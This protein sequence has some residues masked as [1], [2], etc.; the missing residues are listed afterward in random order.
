MGCTTVTD[1]LHTG[2]VVSIRSPLT[3]T[4]TSCRH[5]S[6]TLTILL[7]AEGHCLEHFLHKQHPGWTV[8][9]Y[10]KHR[11]FSLTSIPVQSTEAGLYAKRHNYTVNLRNHFFTPLSTKINT[12]FITQQVSP[13]P[14][15]DS[16][17]RHA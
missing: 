2:S 8:S 4:R 17:W 12:V 16:S 7:E 6:V 5:T 1:P 14:N 9:R 13:P 15:A 10:I 11:N 3:R